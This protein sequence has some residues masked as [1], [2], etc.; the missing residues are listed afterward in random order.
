MRRMTMSLMHHAPDEEVRV[1]LIDS[2]QKRTAEV[3]LPVKKSI[4]FLPIESLRETSCAQFGWKACEIAHCLDPDNFPARLY[5]L[6]FCSG[7]NHV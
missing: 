1:R 3:D 7:G 5:R 4:H 6:V 2:Q